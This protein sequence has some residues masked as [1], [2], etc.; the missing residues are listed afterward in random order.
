MPPCL[1][2]T[3]KVFFTNINWFPISLKIK[4]LFL[5]HDAN[6]V[7][8]LDVPSLR[9]LCKK[10]RADD[11][12][13]N[14]RH[15][16]HEC[17]TLVHIRIYAPIPLSPHFPHRFKVHNDTQRILEVLLGYLIS[18]IRQHNGVRMCVERG[19]GQ[20]LC[21]ISTPPSHAMPQHNKCL[22]DG[23]VFSTLPHTPCVSTAVIN[24][25]S[26]EGGG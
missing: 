9:D 19:A 18:R 3:Y 6:F 10:K 1:K 24:I 14:E 15:A 5:R 23:K 12:R 4:L 7:I 11:H 20:G 2:V 25:H 16:K 22:D 13:R 8:M 17:G 21:L 26:M